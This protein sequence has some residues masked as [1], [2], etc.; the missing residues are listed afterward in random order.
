MPAKKPER[1]EDDGLLREIDFLILAAEQSGDTRDSIRLILASLR[2]TNA[3]LRGLTEEV[4][5]LREDLHQHAQALSAVD[6][7]LKGL[8]GKVGDGPDTAFRQTVSALQK[9]WHSTKLLI[10][11]LFLVG[12]LTTVCLVTLVILA[13]IYWVNP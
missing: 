12:G 13:Q 11:S 7:R 10:V 3:R 6:Q 8:E 4:G 9:E 2:D 1:L 5:G